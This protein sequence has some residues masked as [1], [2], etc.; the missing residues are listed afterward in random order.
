VSFAD[1]RT[2]GSVRATRIPSYA[3]PLPV[4]GTVHPAISWLVQPLGIRFTQPVTLALPNPNSLPAGRRVL[5]FVAD[6]DHHELVRAGF[7]KVSADGS[8][9]APDHALETRSLEVFG[10]APLTPEQSAA[11]DA[12]IAGAPLPAPPTGIV[13]GTQGLLLKPSEPGWAPWKLFGIRE[14]QAQFFVGALDQ[15]ADAIVAAYAASPSFL[16]GRVRTP[17]Q[18]GIELDVDFS[19][20]NRPL[21]M[22]ALGDDF[23]APGPVSVLL[24]ADA[25]GVFKLSASML[26]KALREDA[27]APSYSV[28]ATFSATDPNHVSIAPP[29][30]ENWSASIDAANANPSP[31]AATV[32]LKYGTSQIDLDAVSATTKAHVTFSALLEPATNDPANPAGAAGSGRSRRPTPPSSK[33]NSRACAWR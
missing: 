18:D 30:G 21:H 7:G 1:G 6:A 22:S 23:W 19:G 20:A 26:A 14:A 16:V 27:S 3:V 8:S 33:S 31:I 25:S 13:P 9:I 2:I 24:T 29:Q 28:S 32:E 5:L 17:R 15:Q 12:A 11:V 10:F 4:D